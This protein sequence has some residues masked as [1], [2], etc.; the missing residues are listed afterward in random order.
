MYYGTNG[1]NWFDAEDP[2]SRQWVI[3]SVL[4]GQTF[5]LRYRADKPDTNPEDRFKLISLAEDFKNAGKHLSVVYCINIKD[6][7][8]VQFDYFTE[9]KESG[10]DIIAVEFG[11]E[12]YSKEQA[13]FNFAV[14]ESWFT[15]VKSLIES[16]YPTMKF[17]IFLAPR[18]KESGV[19]GGRKDHSTFNNAA[20][21]YI[22]TYANCHPT[23]HIYFNDRECPV[24]VTSPAKVTYTPGTLFPELETYYTDLYDQAMANTNLW[25]YTLSY[26]ESSLPS[27][28]VYITEWGFDNYGNI[29]NTLAT[30]AVAWHIWNTYGKDPRITALLQ[31]NG[32]SKAGP[33]FIFPVHPTNDTPEPS[34][35][36]NK[37]RVDYFIYKMFRAISDVAT[38]PSVISEPG[39][40]NYSIPLGNI[41]DALPIAV[42]PSLSLVG[43]EFDSLAGK[44]MYSSAGA[45][46]WM[47]KNS[48]PSYEINDTDVYL[49]EDGKAFGYFKITVDVM[50]PIN[51]KPTVVIL[52]PVPDTSN[53]EYYVGSTIE[54]V[55]G[56][57]D[58]DGE[59]TSYKWMDTNG[60]TLGTS[61]KLTIPVLGDLNTYYVFVKDD[62][63]GEATAFVNIRGVVKPV[64]PCNKPWWCFLRPSH[65][66]CKCEETKT[67][68]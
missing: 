16:T 27:K 43:I 42:D 7:A 23:I 56:A 24:S 10:V 12:T 54:L 3:D 63:D 9:V 36:S 1:E 17:L 59:I 46:E 28:E 53:D 14:Y 41:N 66:R 2:I 19:L 38:A 57:A 68:S 32:I 33:G 30:G 64:E 60:N 20:I 13:N 65:K 67:N 5:T 49:P 18:P 25:D 8:N 22:N 34:G 61:S 26:L 31:H 29:K 48:T 62:K 39:V 50:L 55:A 52:K 11:N 47:A 21:A 45:T 35:S 40:Y 58:S 15:P 44:Y 4:P 37:R 51:E 6:D